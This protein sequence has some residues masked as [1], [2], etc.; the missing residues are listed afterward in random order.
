MK[1][2]TE[3]RCGPR[4]TCPVHN[5]PLIWWPAGRLHACQDIE[6]IYHADLDLDKE[7][8][9]RILNRYKHDP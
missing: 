5:T 2:E 3:H 4:C 8:F 7:L 1:Y 9:K 6:C